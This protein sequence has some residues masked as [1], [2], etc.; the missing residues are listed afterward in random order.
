MTDRVQG[1]CCEPA[2]SATT[3]P[4]AEATH[5]RSLVPT[6]DH[7]ERRP[8][9]CFGCYEGGEPGPA[10]ACDTCCGHGNED[11]WCV[12]I[13]DLPAWAATVSLNADRLVEER[14]AFRAMVVD[15]LASAHPHPVEH[16][17]MTAAWAKA[18]ELLGK[19]S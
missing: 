8:A 17:T 5:L 3:E 10:S 19:Y 18:Q 13:V 16:P 15:L 12:P 1:C 2:P 11:G 14:D 7:C 9:A 6:C 4:L